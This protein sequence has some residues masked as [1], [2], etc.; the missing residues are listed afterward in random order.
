MQYELPDCPD[1][2]CVLTFSLEKIRW[3]TRVKAEKVKVSE[4]LINY[5]SVVCQQP[6]GPFELTQMVLS[7]VLD[8]SF[9][10]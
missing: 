5:N 4:T 10:R 7:S 1:A 3:I 8:V 6:P 2:V 9:S